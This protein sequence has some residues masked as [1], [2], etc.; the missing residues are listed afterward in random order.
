[1]I[2]TLSAQ[3]CFYPPNVYMKVRLVVLC[4][5]LGFVV[6]AAGAAEVIDGGQRCFMGGTDGG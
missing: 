5:N 1:M 4:T 2:S 6:E 3:T